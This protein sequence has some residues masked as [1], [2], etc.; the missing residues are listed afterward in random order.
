MAILKNYATIN[1]GLII[2]E[3][4]ILRTMSKAKSV[5]SM[6]EVDEEFPVGCQIYNLDKFLQILSVFN[7][8]EIDWQD[9]YAIIHSGKTK[10]KYGYG[11]DE[12]SVSPKPPT[13]MK[14][15][16]FPAS[17]TMTE[18][19]L[20]KTLKMAKILEGID[21]LSISLDD[22]GGQYSL[23]SSEGPNRMEYATEVD[24]TSDDEIDTSIL[25]DDLK[26]LPLEYTVDVSETAVRFTNE[27]Y[28]IWYLV[29]A[30]SDD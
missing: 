16:P 20:G 22:S 14:D 30:S 29:A 23:T 21:T 13:T 25:I 27:S 10:L 15:L 9:K 26:L 19:E 11:E 1:Q 12:D 6:A 7:E 8:P 5:V 17:F 28:K 18:Q 4:N 24:C 2:T 3:G